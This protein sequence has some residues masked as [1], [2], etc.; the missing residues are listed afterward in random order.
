MRHSP[1]R[2]AAVLIAP[3]LL[4]AACSSDDESGVESDSDTEATETTAAPEPTG[5][6]IKIGTMIW[7]EPVVDLART[8]YPGIEAAVAAINDSGGINGRPLEWVSC[9]AADPNQGLECA[10]DFVEQGV[11]ATIADANMLVEAAST[12]ILREAGIAQIDPFVSEPE[13][14]ESDNV[15]LLNPGAPIQYAAIPQYLDIDGKDRLH[16]L[17]A[18]IPT[19]EPN[20]AATEQAAEFFGV[21]VDGQTEV[22]LTAADYTPM[23]SAADEVDAD[24]NLAVIAPFM[25]DLLMQSAEQLGIQMKIGLAEGQFTQEQFELYGQEGGPLGGAYL[26]DTVPPIPMA[27]DYPELQRAL[28]EIEA[29]Y[30]ETGDEFAA[31]EA[32]NSIVIRAWLAVQAFDMVASDLDEVN[33]AT[34]MEGFNT[35]E[36]MDLGLM[37]PWTP[38]AEGPPGYENVSN[39]WQYLSTVE[40]GEVVLY[41]DD[42]IDATIP[43]QE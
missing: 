24:A 3:V 39:P 35:V 1:I 12:E 19:A 21:E 13:A 2:W 33:A 31:P 7:S 20:V 10:N 28:D 30:E 4:L 38:S 6:P 8:R 15:F 17:A 14:F 26:V 40:D 25:T 41:Q 29:Y 37:P 16:V 36:D 32:L 34:V 23:V 43:F 22:P 18:T 9:E 11:V 5:E 42:P 27:D